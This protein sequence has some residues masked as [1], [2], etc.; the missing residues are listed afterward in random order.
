MRVPNLHTAPMGHLIKI[1]TFLKKG[2]GLPDCMNKLAKLLS[3][4]FV[5]LCICPLFSLFF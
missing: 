4:L 5:F 1:G 2:P 3:M